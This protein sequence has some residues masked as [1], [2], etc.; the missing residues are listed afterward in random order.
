MCPLTSCFFL[1]T[2]VIVAVNPT[3]SLAH[4]RVPGDISEWASVKIKSSSCPLVCSLWVIAREFT[5]P[6]LAFGASTIS[7]SDGML[8][9]CVCVSMCNMNLSKS[10]EFTPMGLNWMQWVL[11]CFHQVGISYSLTLSW[12]HLWESAYKQE[13]GSSRL[14]IPAGSACDKS[15]IH[16]SS[17]ERHGTMGRFSPKGKCFGHPSTS[18][19]LQRV[20]Q[21]F[22]GVFREVAGMAL[23]CCGADSS[24]A[25]VTAVPQAPPTVLWGMWLPTTSHPGFF[26]L[27]VGRAL[28]SKGAFPS[29]S[30]YKIEME[31]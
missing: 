11:S 1:C 23:R 24:S 6:H 14:L 31:F 27:D 15:L 3:Q 26:C 12:L 5:P 2:L 8:Q 28:L 22:N 19:Q 13:R 30:L 20:M 29:C 18:R 16:P 17:V 4:P 10:L 7:P 9:E 21:L 25:G